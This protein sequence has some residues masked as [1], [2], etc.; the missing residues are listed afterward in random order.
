MPADAGWRH[1]PRR[2]SSHSW[3]LQVWRQPPGVLT[4]LLPTRVAAP[5]A[6]ASGS[7]TGL[8]TPPANAGCAPVGCASRALI[9]WPKFCSCWVVV[10]SRSSSFWLS[11][12]MSDLRP[13]AMVAC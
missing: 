7:P 5:P 3:G 10:E 4:E 8:G 11:A 12:R 2:Q 13:S 9:R 1:D 6:D